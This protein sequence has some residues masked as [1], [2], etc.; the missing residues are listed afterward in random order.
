MQPKEIEVLRIKFTQAL[1]V[2][3]GI[4]FILTETPPGG[5]DEYFCNPILAHVNVDQQG[6]RWV[7]YSVKWSTSTLTPREWYPISDDCGWWFSGHVTGI[8]IGNSE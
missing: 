3:S 1:P 5:V 4:L 6:N 7:Q 8:E 2:K